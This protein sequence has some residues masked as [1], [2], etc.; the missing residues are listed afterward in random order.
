M[1]E[2]DSDI[3]PGLSPGGGASPDLTRALADIA[4]IRSQLAAGALFQGFGPAVVA[5]TG[6]LAASAM[7]A[8]MLWPG[9]FAAGEVRYL[10][11][12]VVVAV[13]A[14]VMVAAEMVSR[15]RRR[16]GGMATQMIL[17]A[18]EQFLPAGVA[19]AAIA[20]SL[21]LHAS[22]TLWIAPGLWQILMALGVFAAA[23]ML[24]RGVALV[25]AWYFVSGVFVLLWAAQTR[26]LAPEMMGV[27]FT[28][29]QLWLA[30]VLHTADG[31]LRQEDCD[32][33]S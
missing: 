10:L 20:W 23:R 27:P 13:V 29:G 5:G 19:G 28:V 21:A 3:G 24:P 9:V 4:D 14:G 6:A 32:A 26:V 7:A 33:E 22:D 12:W 30:W 15:S 25:G 17:C 8:Q 31:D 16:H 2:F 1:R 18:L 11:V